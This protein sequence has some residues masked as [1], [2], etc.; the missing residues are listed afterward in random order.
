[1]RDSQGY[2]LDWGQARYGPLY[3]DLPNYFA[4]DDALLYRDALAERGHDIPRATFLAR[5]D[6]ARAYPGFKY[7]G[8]AFHNWFCGDPPHR[9]SDVEYWMN[10]V[11][12]GADKSRWT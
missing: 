1:V 12:Q 2:V 4:R 7:F 9:R 6:A 8:F 3:L 5:Y 11:L 10:M